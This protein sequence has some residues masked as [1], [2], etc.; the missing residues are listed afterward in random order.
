M[1]SSF[2]VHSHKKENLA[3]ND[4][5]I[6]LGGNLG[7]VLSSFLSARQS[8]MKLPYC[9][10]LQ[11]SKLYQTTAVGPKGQPDYLNAAIAIRTQLEPFDLL[12]RLQEIENQHGRIRQ[13]HWGARTLDLDILAYADMQSESNILCLPHKQLHLRQFVLRPLCDIAPTWQHPIIR[14]SAQELLQDLLNSG[15]N[16]LTTGSIW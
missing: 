4:A 14:K 10:V 7:D 9:E 15:E 1:D 5:W 8:I 12:Q 3:L 13:E 2:I 6:A 16:A 11:S